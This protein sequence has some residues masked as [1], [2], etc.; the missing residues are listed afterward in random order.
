MEGISAL[1][2][3]TKTEMADHVKH[4]ERDLATIR[5]GRA[6]AGLLENIRVDY[7]GTQTPIK[8]MAMINILIKPSKRP[9]WAPAR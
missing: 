8:Q 6:S 1:I 4:L 9:I 7:Y 5:T 2:S 3:K